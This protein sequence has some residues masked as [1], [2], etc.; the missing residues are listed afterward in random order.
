MIL[1][2]ALSL[3]SLDLFMLSKNRISSVIMSSSNRLYIGKSYSF[4]S[5]ISP[6]VLFITKSYAMK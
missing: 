3:S 5:S 6:V 1:K 2:Q 4:G